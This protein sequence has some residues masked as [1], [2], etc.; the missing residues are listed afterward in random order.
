MQRR[1]WG[2]SQRR[3]AGSPWSSSAQPRSAPTSPAQMAGA[4]LLQGQRDKK[5][6]GEKEA[7]EVVGVRRDDE[8]T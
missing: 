6:G 3:P 5:G 1:G 2:R 7:G 4:G 8:E